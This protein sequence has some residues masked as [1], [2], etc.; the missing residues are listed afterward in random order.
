MESKAALRKLGQDT[1]ERFSDEVVKLAAGIV[2]ERAP[3]SGKSFAEE[4]EGDKSREWI[5]IG[6]TVFGQGGKI[7]K[8]LLV[9]N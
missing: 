2:V 6:E 4:L 5:A 3:F 7:K 9:L 1:V 8:M